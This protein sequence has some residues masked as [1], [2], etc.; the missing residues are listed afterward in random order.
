M[1]KVLVDTNVFIS[2]IE[3][4][5][6][7][8]IGR[9]LLNSDNIV[10]CAS[11]YTLIEIRDVLMKKKHKSRDVADE[12]IHRV[13]TKVDEIIEIFPNPDRVT[14]IH[15]ETLIDPPDCILIETSKQIDSDF[16]TFEREIQD[17]G[18]EDPSGL[19]E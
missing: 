9:K 19:I 13:R 12:I 7:S 3:A 15:T 4:S 2:V 16:A 6:G 18:A 11:F 14:S 8:E 10:I 1:T 17:H 5:E